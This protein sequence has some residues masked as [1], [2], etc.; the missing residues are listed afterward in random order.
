MDINARAERILAENIKPYG[1]MY[2]I[3]RIWLRHV[4]RKHIWEKGCRTVVFGYQD[5]VDKFIQCLPRDHGAVSGEYTHPDDWINAPGREFENEE[6]VKKI[7]GYKIDKLVIV[8][9]SLR[10]LLQMYLISWDVSYEIIDIYELIKKE[11]KKDVVRS[12]ANPLEKRILQEYVRWRLRLQSSETEKYCDNYDAILVKKNYVKKAKNR[13]DKKYYLRELIINY[14]LIR[15]YKNGFFYIDQYTQIFGRNDNPFLRIKQEFLRL[16]SQMKKELQDKKEK[17]IIV[18]WCDALPYS[19]FKKYHFLEKIEKESLIF[20]NTYT[21]IPYTH[22]TS[23]SMFTGIPF[24]EGKLYRNV[25]TKNMIR[26]GKTL[27]LL[28]KNGYQICEIG[29][30]YIKKKYQKLPEYTVK[31]LYTPAAMHLWETLAQLLNDEGEKKFVIC[32]MDCE[33]HNPY[34]NGNS[35]KLTLDPGRFLRE[36][37]SEFEI[38]RAESAYYLEQQILFYIKFLG[39]NVCRI[40]MSDHGIG[41]P[42]YSER[43]LHAFCFVKDQGIKTGN[44][45]KIFSYLKFYELV[46]Y[47]LHPTEENFDKIFS[48]YALIQNDHPYG[49]KYCREILYKLEHN[50][51]IMWKNWMGFRGIIKELL[52]R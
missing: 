34:W 38:Q 21:H 39:K 1:K 31:C 3:P 24:F 5:D 15:D 4:I 20:E 48:D 2:Y 45:K 8:S 47:V 43:R 6:L 9:D 10:Y 27:E 46:S 36:D 16:F 25:E 51:D 18:F 14:F 52:F 12:I 29:G 30:N 49:P 7:A 50:E 19:D 17:D 22:T 11:Y 41:G 28:H 37:M 26:H 23:Q 40:F 32:H 13:K 33:L 44:Y 42:A 35:E